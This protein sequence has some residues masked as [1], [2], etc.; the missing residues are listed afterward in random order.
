M[1]DESIKTQLKEVFSG[2][3]K[4][5]TLKISG[6]AKDHSDELSQMMADLSE[7]SESISAEFSQDGEHASVEIWVEGKNTGITFVGAPGGHEFSSFVIALMNAS[8]K[9]KLPDSDIQNQILAIKGP[10]DLTTYIS[11]SCTNCPEVVQNLNLIASLHPEISHKVVDGAVDPEGAKALEVASVPSVF[12]DSKLVTAGRQTLMNL[13]EKLTESFGKGELKDQG[14]TQAPEEFDV[15]V[16]GGGPAGISSAIYAARKGLSTVIVAGDLGG[17]LNETVG[18]ENFIATPYIEGKPLVA[19]LKK[20]IADYDIKVKEHRL[21]SSLEKTKDER[22]LVSLNSGGKI[23]ARSLIVATGAKWKNLGVE[24]EKEYLGK[25]VAYCP[26]CDGP[27]YKGKDVVVVGGGNSGIEAAIDLSGIVKS[28]TVLEFNAELKADQV[29]VS[30]AEQKENIRIIKNAATQSINGDQGKVTSITVQNRES[31]KS[32][33]IATD[34]VFVQIGLVP[35]SS[36]AKGFVD[37]NEYGE[38]VIDEK[39]QTSVKGVF[40]AGD[41][42]TVP[43]K[44]INISIGEGSKAALSAAE[45]L[46]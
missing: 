21:V 19:N 38:I 12:A 39:N 40:A 34:A 2:L 24:G 7:L 3:D 23:L 11:L 5:I 10:I 14:E 4:K 13:I 37:L 8:G 45:Y 41:V 17:Q 27:L 20:H 25:G 30:K 44:Q 18:I 32:E 22:T 16:I 36:F 9:G 6:G 43:Y 46:M 29:L 26:H 1:L 35:N 31:E 33:D 15:A 28:V 42:S